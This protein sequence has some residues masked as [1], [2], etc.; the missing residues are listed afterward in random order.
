VQRALS[1]SRT[2]IPVVRYRDFLVINQ[3]EWEAIELIQDTV[4]KEYNRALYWLNRASLRITR[5]VGQRILMEARDQA[6]YQ[7]TLLVHARPE[8][9]LLV[10]RAIDASA[11]SMADLIGALSFR[12]DLA[13]EN[14]VGWARRWDRIDPQLQAGMVN[15]ACRNAVIAELVLREL[16]FTGAEPISV[17]E[18]LLAR[19]EPR[20][21]G[22][23]GRMAMRISPRR[24]RQRLQRFLESGSDSAM[25]L[26]QA[27]VDVG[28]PPSALPKSASIQSVRQRWSEELRDNVA[29][30]QVPEIR[31]NDTL[32]QAISSYEEALRAKLA[33]LGGPTRT[34]EPPSALRLQQARELLAA[35][36]SR[37]V[38]LC[39]QPN[40]GEAMALLIETVLFLKETQ[41]FMEVDIAVLLHVAE[42]LENRSFLASQPLVQAGQQS[43]GLYLIAKGQVEVTQARKGRNLRIAVLGP[44]D[45]IGELSALND[46]PATADCT[47]ITPVSCYFLPSAVLANLLHQHPRLS[48]GLIRM[49][50][51]RLMS[52]TLRVS[53][54]P[55]APATLPPP[56]AAEVG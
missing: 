49:L 39:A 31:A 18:T 41:V 47:A 35:H 2:G 7:T 50:S 11:A 29:C 4:L 13:L 51:H 14:A 22:L 17:V 3:L 15:L 44:R 8:E 20:L 56:P 19:G 6:W 16:A 23:F 53:D 37:W 12:P 10:A 38:R 55:P 32:A 33:P 1:G 34:S 24:R 46:T 21:A 26:L 36:P 9:Q 30:L 25:R 54:P 42:K 43:G 40:N 28:L 52:T 5:F 27:M 45:S 48:I